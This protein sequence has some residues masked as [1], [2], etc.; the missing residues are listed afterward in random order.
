VSAYISR[1]KFSFEPQEL[2]SQH[3][4]TGKVL[5]LVKL[6]SKARQFHHPPGIAVAS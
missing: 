4:A 2:I 5:Y 3:N 6:S 1:L